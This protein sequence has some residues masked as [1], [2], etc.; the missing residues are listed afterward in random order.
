M[1]LTLTVVPSSETI[2]GISAK[3]FHTD[4]ALVGLLPS[5]PTVATARATRAYGTETIS[6]RGSITV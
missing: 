4:I 2:D 6:I 1:P 5:K 3:P